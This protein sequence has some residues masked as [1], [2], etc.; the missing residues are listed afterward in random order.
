[1]LIDFEGKVKI[2]D[3]GLSIDLPSDG[4]TGL[5]GSVPYMSPEMVKGKPYAFGT[6]IWSCGVAA[7]TMLYGRYPYEAVLPY[8]TTVERRIQIVKAIETN[9]P[10]PSFEPLAS[11]PRPARS[12]RRFI[13]TLLVRDPMQRPD[14]GMC[15]KLS[16][17]L[18]DV[19]GFEEGEFAKKINYMTMKGAYTDAHGNAESSCAT[20][21][22]SE[23]TANVSVSGGS[24]SS[25]T[26]SGECVA[27]V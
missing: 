21:C 4:L 3:F 23:S 20:V 13:E 17:S 9:T 2:A 16:S 5:V 1:M 7:Y 12:V 22:P 25:P 10:A 24:S 6:D 8:S 11:V 15:S 27:D 19:K 26:L 14:A 18:K